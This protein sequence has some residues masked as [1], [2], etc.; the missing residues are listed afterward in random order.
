[1]IS[2]TA[3]RAAAA[4]SALVLLA[5]VTGG[6]GEAETTAAGAAQQAPEEAFREGLFEELN[7][8]SYK[9]FITRQ[10]NN[11]DPEDRGY[12]QG[13]DAPP[14]ST[15]YGVFLQVCNMEKEPLRAA[16]DFKVVDTLGN[17]FE[18]TSVP[19]TNIFA[20]RPSTVRPDGCIPDQTSVA[21]QAPTGGA[22]LLFLLPLEASEN[23]PLELEISDGFD[24][25]G[26]P[27][28]L[29]FELDI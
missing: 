5:A 20:Y 2:R 11:R 15:Y 21:A 23:R 1:M 24:A 9:V 10:I 7:G 8:L 14:G 29:S 28:T 18:P 17:E 13:P 3:S 16:S 27:R 25:E 6:C 22:L 4:A 26:E 19:V 12:F